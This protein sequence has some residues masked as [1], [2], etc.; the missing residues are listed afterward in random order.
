MYKDKE[1]VIRPVEDQDLRRLWELTYKEESPEWK[2][3]DAPYFEH[4][5]ISYEKYLTNKDNLVNQ[6]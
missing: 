2:K 5:A 1:V 6:D 4:K 3:W